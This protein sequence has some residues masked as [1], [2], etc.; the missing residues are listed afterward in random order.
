[1]STHDVIVILGL[2]LVLFAI[3]GAANAIVAAIN[4]DSWEL[5]IDAIGDLPEIIV[6]RL[7]N[8]ARRSTSA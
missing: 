5:Q 2:V 6:N 7:V 4:R 3:S 8:A 1:M